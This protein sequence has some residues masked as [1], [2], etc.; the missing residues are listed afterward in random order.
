MFRSNNDAGVPGMNWTTRMDV[1][2]AADGLGATI[3]SYPIVRRW[4]IWRR[5]IWISR[6]GSCREDERH[7]QRSW[8]QGPVTNVFLPSH[9]FGISATYASAVRGI[10][11][12]M[13]PPMTIS[14]QP[15]ISAEGAMTR[16]GFVPSTRHESEAGS[17]S[18]MS[19]TFIRGGVEAL[20]RPATT[21]IRPPCTIVLPSK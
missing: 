6:L 14:F 1:I 18:S 10:G 11:L 21:M 17:Y 4:L 7:G 3:L 13:P 2:R 15:M 20:Q 8:K 19:S 9:H 16:S 12:P 5:P